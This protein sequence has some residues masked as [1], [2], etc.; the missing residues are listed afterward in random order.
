M[1]DT[2]ITIYCLCEGFLEAIATGMTL[3]PVAFG[4]RG[5]RRRSVGRSQRTLQPPPRRRLRKRWLKGSQEGASDAPG[6]FVA[7]FGE[8]ANHAD[9]HHEPQ[10]RMP[11]SER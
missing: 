3:K 8:E 1:D 5:S 7:H 11:S 9:Q 2:I 6:P 4:R 10:R